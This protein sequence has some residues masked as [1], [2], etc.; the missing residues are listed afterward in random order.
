MRLSQIVQAQQVSRVN[1]ADT[2][3]EVARDIATTQAEHAGKSLDALL[4]NFDYGYKLLQNK[5]HKAKPISRAEMPV[6]RQINMPGFSKHL[7]EQG[8]HNKMTETPVSALLPTQ[9]QIWLDKAIAD[10][11]QH[12]K[13]S[14]GDARL[15]LI[16]ITSK[17]G[18]I[19]DGH[20]RFTSALLSDPKLKQRTLLVDLP[21]DKLVP[22]AKKYGESVGNEARASVDD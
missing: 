14:P 19:L 8:I 3:L 18:Y 9:K 22:L 12:G 4:P 1:V 11:L 16:I 10:P 20:H 21:I 17:D 7:T 6:I 5:L 13:L 15:N 2:P